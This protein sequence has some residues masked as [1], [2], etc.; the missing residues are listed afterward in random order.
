MKRKNVPRKKKKPDFEYD[1]S[2][3]EKAVEETRQETA[4]YDFAKGPLLTLTWPGAYSFRILPI[5]Q[6]EDYRRWVGYH[7]GVLPEDEDGRA[8][9]I[10][11][12]RVNS[13]QDCPICLFLEEA[14]ARHL[15]DRSDP[16]W[17]GDNQGRGSIRLKKF[18]LL[19]VLFLHFKG[20]DP[21]KDPDFGELPTLKL[22]R[23]PRFVVGK[24]NEFMGDEDFGPKRLMDLD[25]GL[26]LRVHGSP[27]NEFYWNV[28]T[29][30]KSY[31]I[32]D[33]FRDP[34]LW[35]ET[36][37]F[38]EHI[39]QVT[40]NDVMTLLEKHQ[41]VVDERLI[42]YAFSIDVGKSPLQLTP[43]RESTPEEEDAEEDDTVIN[44]EEIDDGSVGEDEEEYEIDPELRKEL[45]N[46]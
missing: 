22:I 31:S 10:P 19:R 34:D 21:K 29:L 25:E 30:P 3:V 8:A 1:Y 32:P 17:K 7:W 9:P 16:L 44:E 13:G 28:A 15:I 27:K 18:L 41:R 40:T 4:S 46:L 37:R 38:E 12:P 43:L 36:L 45:E 11:C 33:E 23:L 39:P 42:K 20:E 14:L 6:A 26:I 24:I 2:W 35:A 5:R